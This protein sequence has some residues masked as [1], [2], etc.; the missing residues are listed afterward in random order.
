MEIICC[1]T[2]PLDILTKIFD[3]IYCNL[4]TEPRWIGSDWLSTFV[5]RKEIFLW[6][7]FEWLTCRPVMGGDTSNSWQPREGELQQTR[8]TYQL[9]PL[10]LLRPRPRPPSWHCRDWSEIGKISLV[11]WLAGWLGKRC[12][13]DWLWMECLRKRNKTSV[14]W[15]Q[16][17]WNQSLSDEQKFELRP[18]LHSVY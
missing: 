4:Q 5:E 9:L 1:C 8:R 2:K 14:N 15:L 10:L 7:D 13:Q 11:I 6:G 17:H 18:T 16:T 3:S 12:S